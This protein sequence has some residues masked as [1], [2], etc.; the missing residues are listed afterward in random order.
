[1]DVELPGKVLEMVGYLKEEGRVIDSTGTEPWWTAVIEDRIPHSRKAFSG[2]CCQQRPWGRE[3]QEGDKAKIHSTEK[4]IKN[5][6]L[7]DRYDC[8]KHSVITG[9]YN[10]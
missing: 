7:C 5:G 6:T 1:M 3:I 4:E 2:D 10:K 9:L 8:T